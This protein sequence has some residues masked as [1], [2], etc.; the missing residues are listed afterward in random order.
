MWVAVALLV[1]VVL[2][3]VVSALCRV[4]ADDIGAG[5]DLCPHG[6]FWDDCPDC[7]H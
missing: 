4:A 2:G 3:I 6:D 7:R 1:G 5:P